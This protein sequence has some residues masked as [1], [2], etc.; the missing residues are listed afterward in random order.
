MPDKLI[1]VEDNRSDNLYP[2][3]YMR[4]SFELRCGATSLAEKITHAAGADSVA[5]FVRDWLAASYSEKTDHPVND[6]DE[7]EGDVMIVNGRLLVDGSVDLTSIGPDEVLRS[8]DTFVAGR[9]RAQTLAA[10]K[11]AAKAA[12]QALAD[13]VLGLLDATYT[14]CG[15]HLKIRE[16]EATVI[17]YPWLLIYHNA[18]MIESDFRRLYTNPGVHA[19]LHP[20]SCV[21]GDAKDVY[22]APSARIHPL[23]VIDATGGPVVIEED[24]LVLPHTR[25]DG[26]TYI[27]PKCRLVGGKIREAC[28]FGP[29][30]R[31]GGEVECTIM[32]GYSNKYHD[33]FLGHS[34]VCEWVN[35][36]ALT[37]NSDLKNDYTPVSVYYKG[38]L[39]DTGA[40]FVGSMIGDHTKTSIGIILN[41]GSVIGMMSNLVFSGN[42]MPKF[43][44]SFCW[45]LNDRPTKGIGLRGMLET[46]RAAMARRK[47]VLSDADE[48]LM[49]HLHGMLKPELR[50]AIK[51]AFKR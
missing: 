13:P 32:Q 46:A 51:K 45:M 50:E 42:L 21:L 4:P 11:A 49:R 18:R 33:G 25:V 48:Q 36:G 6:F 29:V 24:A 37:T 38:E 41:T 17:D 44:P 20:L 30:C 1:I 5:Y 7:L 16:V 43:V 47:R 15:P 26:P 3:T 40:Q 12:Q 34:Y 31:V 22:I 19:E 23:V 14:A 10:G 9:I 2:L 39:M 35:L 28:S 27:G 8:G